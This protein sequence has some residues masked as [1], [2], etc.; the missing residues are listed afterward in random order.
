[1]LN[2]KIACLGPIFYSLKMKT[3]VH[4]LPCSANVNR[5]NQMLLM[6]FLNPFFNPFDFDFIH[7]N[8]KV[9]NYVSSSVCGCGNLS[10]LKGDRR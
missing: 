9:S 5:I 8:T 10:E 1:M 6:F 7:L 4:V 3:L 2:L